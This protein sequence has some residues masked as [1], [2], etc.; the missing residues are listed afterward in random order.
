MTMIENGKL[1]TFAALAP[2][3]GALAAPKLTAFAVAGPDPDELYLPKLV[4]YAVI[5][6]PP[7]IGVL[8]VLTW[9]FTL[10]DHDFL[11]IQLAETTLVYDFLVAKW[12]VWG[13]GTDEDG[14]QTAN[15]Q[16]WNANLGAI[17]DTLGG[18]AQSNV[19][20]GDG[21]T[22]A[23][24][25]LDPELAEDY[26][27]LGVAGQPFRR[28][29]TGQIVKR[30]DDYVSCPGVEVTSSAGEAPSGLVNSAVTLTIS[31][32]KGHSF[33]S[34]GS[35]TPGVS[36][37]SFVLSWGSLGSFTG[38]GRLFRI[39]DYGALARVDGLDMPDGG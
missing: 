9:T 25:F 21:E 36:D 15:G 39:T 27:S 1:V 23:L 14:W 13:S 26:S 20:C 37:Y 30:G 22:G 32:D 34:A 29:I 31:D 11:I 24:Y 17:M 33:W 35:R 19:V 8:R 18:Y 2:V 16:N 3:E 4:V 5:G 6:P 12:Y 7:V 38:P 28:V 10:D